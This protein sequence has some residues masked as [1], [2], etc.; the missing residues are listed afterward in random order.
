MFW[1]SALFYVLH[2]LN[3]LDEYVNDQILDILEILKT[4]LKFNSI[5]KVILIV[6]ALEES[7]GVQE[8]V[9]EC[10]FEFLDL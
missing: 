5:A 1:T 2:Q 9:G 4:I 8:D 6:F 3:Q 10:L 7:K